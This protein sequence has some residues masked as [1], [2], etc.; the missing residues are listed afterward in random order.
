MR[1]GARKREC[2][3]DAAAASLDANQ[4]LLRLAPVRAPGQRRLEHL[5]S[6]IRF[7]ELEV[8]PRCIQLGFRQS[9]GGRFLESGER[10]VGQ[11]GAR[12]DLG[13]TIER[14]LA[15][16]ADH[17]RLIQQIA[18]TRRVALDER[19]LRE[20]QTGLDRGRLDRDRLFQPLAGL[21]LVAA[22]PGQLRQSEAR[23]LVA[24]AR[25]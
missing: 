24:A 25:S 10:L 3:V 2:T 14:R 21:L 6:L 4:Q 9:C 13:R 19:D 16:A 17:G 7:V 23:R 12:Q 22:R 20:P 11:P 5:A 15:I 18:T 8:Q 1:P